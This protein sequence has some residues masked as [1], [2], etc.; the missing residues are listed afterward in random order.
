MEIISC[1]LKQSRNNNI[2]RTF[3]NCAWS[4]QKEE[5]HSTS[6]NSEDFRNAQWQNHSK[7]ANVSLS[8][9]LGKIRLLNFT[10]TFV[11][12]WNLSWIWLFVSP[13]MSEN[14]NIGLKTVKK[15]KQ[16]RHQ[17]ISFKP[18]SNWII[19]CPKDSALVFNFL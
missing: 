15:H 8:Y 2:F 13:Y 6:G 14:E 4:L 5:T 17:T 12:I 1:C 3:E 7:K 9:L 19:K 11:E 18:I 10:L 16:S